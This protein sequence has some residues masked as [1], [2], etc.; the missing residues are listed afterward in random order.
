MNRIA[1]RKIS[2]VDP[3]PG[4]TRDRVGTIVEITP[5]PARGDQPRL[6]ELTD[7][8]GYGIYTAEGAR[9][10]DV[11]ADLSTLTDDIELQI[12]LATQKAAVI[13]LVIDAQSGVTPLDLTIAQMIR[14]AGLGERVVVVANKVDDEKWEAHAAEASRLGF[15][16]AFPVSALS[17]HR[18]RAL[19][20][21]IWNHL[22]PLDEGDPVAPTEMRLAIIG[23][24]NAG[25]STLV[26]ALAGESRVIVS[27]IAGTTRDSVDVR[28]EMD[29][30]TF[31]VI[32]TAGVRKRKSFA[33]DVEWYAHH[34]MLRA[35]RRADVVFL[36]IDATEDVTQVDKKLTQEVLEQFKPVVLVI[37]KWDLVRDRLAP[38]QYLDY[39]TQELSGVT[40][41]PL[42]FI[43]AETGE[44]VKDAIAMA[45]NL[46]QQANH[47]ETTGK[48]NETVRAILGQRGPSSKL[49]TKAKVLYVSQIGVAP[50]TIAMVVND[51]TLFAGN[52]E[53]YFLNALREELPFAEV[54]IRLIFSKRKRRGE[55][56]ESSENHHRVRS[57][58]RT[59]SAR[60][61]EAKLARQ[62]ALQTIDAD[63]PSG[64]VSE[65]DAV[66]PVR[67]LMGARPAL[68]SA[69]TR[70][71][72][73]RSG[74]VRGGATEP[75]AA[76]RTQRPT[77][78]SR[79]GAKGTRGNA[80]MA[81]KLDAA[82]SKVPTA[83]RSGA[84]R[85]TVK[86][87]ST[88][89]PGRS[90]KRSAMAGAKRSPARG[91]AAGGKSAG[92][93][94]ARSGA[95]TGAASSRGPRS[96]ASGRSSSKPR[97]GRGK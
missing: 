42:A 88:S 93:A 24:R 57:H 39:L 75:A 1:G 3:T 67:P 77:T 6:I 31:T 36:L 60:R 20:E 71:G 12:R 92:R 16:E 14:K 95:A 85:S 35:I 73:A 26:N 33:D 43:S 61:D 13:L 90:A 79:A 8:G 19:L 97:G 34:R 86:A 66:A 15:G 27:E 32:D 41:A 40:F 63:E 65:E 94:G 51:P 56:E 83:G 28:I 37:N 5:P 47:R 58:E 29:G 25:K 54:P 11:G 2:I 10:D 91:A 52:Y 53:R 38:E 44:G 78:S 82:K 80:A 70:A 84:G 45:W 7:T 49:G 48:L 87:S 9:F 22:P 50:P 64:D 21:A 69:P 72:S 89:G 96:G 17:G 68:P 55:E 23:R 18:K 74:S 46:F 4:V 59:K 81:R 30:H 76:K 62:T